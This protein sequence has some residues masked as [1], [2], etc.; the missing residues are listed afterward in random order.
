MIR[1]RRQGWALTLAGLIVICAGS[2]PAPVA[3]LQG[4]E[5]QI[6]ADVSEGKDFVLYK[7]SQMLL[8]DAELYVLNRGSN[9]V[10][11]F[12]SELTFVRS[13]GQEGPGPGELDSARCIATLGE[14]LFV[15][16]NGRLSLFK[17]S[18]SFIKEVPIEYRA[19]SASAVAG[20]LLVFPEGMTPAAYILG[21]D[22]SLAVPVS[23][24]CGSGSWADKQE[25]CGFMHFAGLA[26]D[27]TGAE[28]AYIL[29]KLRGGLLQLDPKTWRVLNE[30][31]D[32]FAGDWEFTRSGY[33]TN[34]QLLCS[35]PAIDCTGDLVVGVRF[36]GAGHQKQQLQV[37]SLP[38]GASSHSYSMPEDFYADA[39]LP[40]QGGEFLA[41]QGYESRI[42]KLK[43]HK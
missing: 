31:Q 18:G 30:R 9:E 29:D 2:I 3:A 43:V 22:Y 7:P 11:V 16:Q 5:L 6:A 37:I 38:D 33:S 10:L 4:K 21:D 1:R 36:S 20:E 40:L 19:R 32:A 39:V 42:V 34:Y 23:I 8:A 35:V 25:R 41:L 15:F 28:S 24:Q 17:R 12:T 13:I 14:T 27:E 26:K